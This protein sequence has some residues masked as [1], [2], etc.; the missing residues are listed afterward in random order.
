MAQAIGDGGGG[1][2]VVKK[3]ATEILKEKQAAETA[4][5]AKAV[6]ADPLLNKA[7]IPKD[8]PVGQHYTW[9]GG[10]TTGSW[11]LY[12]DIVIPGAGISAQGV[13]TGKY[14]GSGTAADPFT[15]DG[16]PFNGTFGGTAYVNGVIKVSS[17]AANTPGGITQAQLDEAL[18]NQLKTL[19]ATK[20]EEAA[21]AA[22]L[23]KKQ[24]QA[25]QTTALEDFKASM[26]MAGLG[27]LADTIDG[28]IK[29]DLTA[30]QVKIEI[31]KTEAYEKR[32]P[33]MKLLRTK[34]QAINEATYISQERG[35]EQ[36]LRAY[37]LDLKAFGTRE[38]LGTYIENATSPV[39]FE[40]RVQM[41]AER[42]KD[43]SEILGMLKT[44]YNV[45]TATAISYLL[46]NKVGLDIIKKQVR[47]AEIGA[48]AAASGFYFGYTQEAMAAGA[49]GL[50]PAVGTE[51]LFALKSDFAKARTFADAQ[52][53]LTELEGDKP[54]NQMSAV[55]AVVGQDQ[56]TIL[57]SQKR[58]ARETARFGGTAGVTAKSLTR[59]TSV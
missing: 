9:I 22:L 54:Y 3:T 40:S 19:A 14:A 39:E 31:I 23:L 52:Q 27:D 29:N 38:K 55:K 30:S 17:T 35:F 16:K 8:A 56:A 1:V 21:A 49:E 15:L 13:T 11:K 48:A 12:N 53:R 46:D 6:A 26:L 44:Y 34:G 51:D 33:G 37:G 2:P 45:D 20:A 5:R 18:A 42:V 41:A 32:F 10:T 50:I 28:Y 57:E 25:F 47:G 7:V 58:A 4:A 43:K 24:N 36:V 59:S